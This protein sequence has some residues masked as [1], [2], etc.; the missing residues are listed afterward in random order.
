MNPNS[1]HSIS[2]FQFSKFQL[3]PHIAITQMRTLLAA[4]E[5][6]TLIRYV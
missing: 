4:R 2:K 6:I 1:L 5:T 3:L